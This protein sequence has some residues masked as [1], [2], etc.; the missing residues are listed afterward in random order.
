MAY[1]A[2]RSSGPVASR[3][4]L[5]HLINTQDYIPVPGVH[6]AMSARLA[7]QA[8]YPVIYVGSYSTSASSYG[9]PD[10]GALTA[11]ELSEAAGR[12]ARAVKVPVIADAENGFHSAANIW[13]TVQLFELAGVAAIH[14]EDQEFGKHLDMQQ[15][16]V[17]AEQ[18]VDKVQAAIDA[19]RDPNL[20]IIA[21]SDALP[22][23]GD[24]SDA[25][26]RV[27]LYS[28][29][30]ADLVFLA[31]CNPTQ[32]AMMRAD[33]DSKVVVT[34]SIGYT[35][36]DER[37]AGADVV[38]YYAMTLYSAFEA[39]QKSL[40]SWRQNPSDTSS[41]PLLDSPSAFEDFIGLE[42]Y[43]KHARKFAMP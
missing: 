5:R 21:R 35:A 42:E 23:N 14:I 10:V 2:Q 27:N 4:V 39:V 3:K 18:M 25:V 41:V 1:E 37:R 15:K 16:L 43:A 8:G 12:V 26:R 29:A 11:T 20:I 38:L 36:E 28:E 24:I 19:R 30:G 13:R 9:L 40:K 32:L 6:D 22:A 33:I 31:G 7:E 17:P 34:N